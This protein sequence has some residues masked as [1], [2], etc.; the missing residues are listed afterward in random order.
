MLGDYHAELIVSDEKTTSAPATVHYSTANVAPVAE[1]LRSH[2]SP[3]AV[4]YTSFSYGRPSLNFYCHCQVLP[5]SRNQ[6]R[7]KWTDEPV[8]VDV[9]LWPQFE[10]A[11]A[12]ALDRTDEFVLVAPKLSETE[13]F[14]GLLLATERTV[15][16][17]E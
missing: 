3:N 6:L 14:S 15:R 12:I 8:L 10:R 2:I 13:T 11:G 5:A 16:G 9:K 7:Q 1:M 4:V 17:L